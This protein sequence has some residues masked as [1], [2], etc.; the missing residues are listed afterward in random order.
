MTPISPGEV[1]DL[2]E[3]ELSW[4]ERTMLLTSAKECLATESALAAIDEPWC[5][6][7]QPNHSSQHLDRARRVHKLINP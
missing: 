1:G 5:V 7:R 6:I 3:P 4:P 2:L